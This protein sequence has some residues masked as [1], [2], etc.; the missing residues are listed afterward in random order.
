MLLFILSDLSR[1]DSVS[2]PKTETGQE[3]PSGYN[4]RLYPVWRSTGPVTGFIGFCLANI[5]SRTEYKHIAT[6]HQAPGATMTVHFSAFC[7]LFLSRIV[8][9]PYSFRHFC[10]YILSLLSPPT[11]MTAIP[12]KRMTDDWHRLLLDRALWFITFVS[13]WDTHFS[14]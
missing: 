1:S 7:L 9:F 5:H 13:F 8:L 2:R 14:P 10:F 4:F 12:R 6:I 3:Y 11:V